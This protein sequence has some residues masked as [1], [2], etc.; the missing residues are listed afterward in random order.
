MIKIEPQKLKWISS[1]AAARAKKKRKGPDKPLKKDK[2]WILRFD[3]SK[4][5]QGD[6]VGID[7]INPSRK[8]FLAAYRLR[9]PYTNNVAKYEA[10]IHGLLFALNKK[11]KILYIYGD[12]KLVVKQVRSVYACNYKKLSNY[13]HRVWD[14]IEEFDAFN[15]MHVRREQNHRANAPAQAANTLEPLSISGMKRFLIELV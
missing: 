11:V 8:S 15:I 7:L 9:F 12:S 3:G 2:P 6:G 1:G 14:L 5:K 13:R 10:L 4:Y